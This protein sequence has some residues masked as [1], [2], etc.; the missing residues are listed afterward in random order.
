MVN[1]SIIKRER[2]GVLLLCNAILLNGT[3][4]SQKCQKLK[5]SALSC[6]VT[7]VPHYK[8]H[9]FA[10]IISTVGNS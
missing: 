4:G 1:V 5:L 8:N 10:L 2:I 7:P 6:I 9:N 3:P